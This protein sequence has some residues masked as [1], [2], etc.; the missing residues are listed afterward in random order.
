MIPLTVYF[1]EEEFL[2]WVELQPEEFYERLKA[3]P[4]LPR[5]SQ[6]SAGAFLE[7]YRRLRETYQR[8]YSVHLSG[9]FSG[10]VASARWRRA[11]STA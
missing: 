10:T 6:P 11:R 5:T 8:V 1:G 7:L 4:E 9:K 3:A 2:D